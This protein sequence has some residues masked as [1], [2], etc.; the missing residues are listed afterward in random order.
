MCKLFIATG[1]FTKDQV[2]HMLR[3][4][5][6][7]F[8][9]S[10]RD[11]FGFIAYGSKK[12]AAYGKYLNPSE[13]LGFGK[14]LPSWVNSNRIEVG[15]IPKVT[16]ALVIHGRTSTNSVLMHN[17]HPFH[18]KGTFLAHNGVL[19]WKGEGPAPTAKHGCDTEQFFNWMQEQG[20]AGQDVA[21]GATA[22]HWTGYGVFGIINTTTGHL[23]V[24]KCGSG[25]LKWVGSDNNHFFST[26]GADLLR[27]TR[28]AK[29]Q[30]SKSADMRPKSRVVFKLNAHGSKVQS[31]TDWK[32]FGTRVIDDSW[33]RSMGYND[34]S[35]S[36]HYNDRWDGYGVAKTDERPTVAVK[37]TAGDFKGVTVPRDRQREMFPDWEPDIAE[38]NKEIEQ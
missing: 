29:F 15:T 28:A 37:P 26:D 18:N 35:R 30:F 23:T 8:A 22:D 11:G 21:W 7:S 34:Y 10:Q 38:L 27:I 14:E 3:A 2:L 24:A 33:R 4:T 20:A 13:Y 17:V 12:S 9:K 31:V 1:S 5:N 32:G 6:A 16:T 25:N 36:S 19:S